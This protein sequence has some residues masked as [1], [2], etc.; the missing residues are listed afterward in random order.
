MVL[1][2]GAS[3]KPFRFHGPPQPLLSCCGPRPHSSLPNNPTP[4]Q[5][6][7]APRTDAIAVVHARP[8]RVWDDQL[9]PSPS[10]HARTRRVR[11]QVLSVAN[12]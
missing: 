4:K 8:R 3:S 12:H 6:Q 5:H 10:F 7:A 9:E 1:E 11:P 2:P